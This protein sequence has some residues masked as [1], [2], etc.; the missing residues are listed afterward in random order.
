MDSDSQVPR[1]G[2]EFREDQRAE[3]RRAT[4]A[5]L[6]DQFLLLRHEVVPTALIHSHPQ[7]RPMLALVIERFFTAKSL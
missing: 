2:S 7:E 1:A 5:F 3:L 4:C 6:W